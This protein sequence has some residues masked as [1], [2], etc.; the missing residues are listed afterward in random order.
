[1]QISGSKERDLR[2]SDK[3]E[4]M[5][6]LTWIVVGAASDGELDG[7]FRVMA[8]GR[9]WTFSWALAARW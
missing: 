2:G 6:L 3:G 1:V 9:L 4:F 8:T 7:F 5:Y